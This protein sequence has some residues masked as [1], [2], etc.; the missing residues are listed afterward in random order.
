[1]T[2]G[3]LNSSEVDLT[4]AG[5]DTRYLTHGLHPYPA[6]MMPLVARWL[7]D[8]YAL[9]S[10]DVVL[11][12]YCGSGGVLVESRLKGR[13]SIGVDINPLACLIARAKSTPIEPKLLEKRA[14]DLLIDIENDL[15]KVVVDV[16]SAPNLDYWFKESVSKDLALIRHYLLKIREKAIRAFLAVCFSITVR[17][18]SNTRSREFK[19]YRIPEEE[20]K[21]HN[22]NSFN[23]FKAHVNDAVKKMR[24]FYERSNKEVYSYVLQ[25]DTRKLTSIDPSKL[26]EETATL[27][28]TSPPYGDSRTTVAYGQFSRYSSLWISFDKNSP[29]YDLG[30]ITKKF[31]LS[32]EE[33]VMKVDNLSLGGQNAKETSPLKS[34]TLDD[35]ISK[36]EKKDEKRAREVASYFVDSNEC[37]KEIYKVLKKGKN[38]CCF[39]LGNRTVKRVQIP[40]DQILVELGR[41]IGFK[42]VKTLHRRIPTKRIPWENA[43]ENITGEK[44]KTMSEEN[45]IIWKV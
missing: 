35:T 38:H 23:I 33:I 45:I 36:I 22:P 9:S 16:P 42:H 2:L 10:D 14:N 12:P 37:L 30:I 8:K 21:K 43:P 27:V 15:G 34:K 5:G 39:V 7:I 31:G 28:V 18:A 13:N 3:Y 20:L 17:E 24:E 41:E 44:G 6:R 32:P 1:M 40:T 29:F 25:G 19:L 4:F 26:A 11:D